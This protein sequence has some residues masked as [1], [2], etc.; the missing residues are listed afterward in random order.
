M[1]YVWD[2]A[3][4]G[5]CIAFVAVGA[6]RGF[7]RSAAHFLGSVISACLA[8]LLG[9][10]VARWVFD[11]M[12]RPALVERIGES[13]TSLGNGDTYTAVQGV[14][15]SL[16][17]FV[18][19][20]LEDAGVTAA[21]VTDALASQSGQAADMI[22][23]ALSPVFISFLKVLAVIVLFS[24]FMVGVRV[25]SNMLSTVF[26]FPLLNGINGLL[27]GVFGFFLAVVSIWIVLAAVRV[28][29]PMLAADT[30]AQVET[31][32]RQS[33]IAGVMVAWN[34]LG[35]MFQ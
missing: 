35:I 10:A 33:V 1:G 20:A 34:P 24:L 30:Q 15:T 26:R 27:G 31:A 4:I 5:V 25:L 18:I 11:T 17:D 29:T 32:L 7:I 23:D 19:R 28:F 2:I 16:P 21:S 13:L 22:A 8:T 14:F 3:F 6:R 12:F 9:G